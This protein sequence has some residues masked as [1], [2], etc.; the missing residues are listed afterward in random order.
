MTDITVYEK[1]NCVQC[2]QS[3]KLLDK[4]NLKY[5]T[6]NVEEDPKAYDYVVTTLGYKAA[7]VIVVKNDEGQV[8]QTWSGFNVEALNS[9]NEGET[10][11][12]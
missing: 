2:K 9:L 10:N 3:K 6:V 7:P 1:N 11:G 8:L 5:N 4:L 12:L